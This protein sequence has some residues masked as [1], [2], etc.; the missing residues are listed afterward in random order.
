M[1]PIFVSGAFI[2][3]L[4]GAGCVHFEQRMEIFADGSAEVEL[5]Y[6]ISE[7]SMR[8]LESGQQLIDTWQGRAS[9]PANWFANEK[10]VRAYL[11]GDGIQVASYRQQRRNGKIHT[12]IVCRVASLS[13][14]LASGKVG[15]FRLERNRQGNFTLSADLVELPSS[16]AE[17]MGQYMAVC[18]DLRLKLEVVTPS[19]IV[20]STAH[21]TGKR[22]VSWEYVPDGDHSVF[23][24]TPEIAVTFEGSGLNWR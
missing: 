16:S 15:D 23:L 11:G 10:A 1:K 19:E 14:T 2:V 8:G 18:Q 12:T 21:Q 7:E 9:T 22:R 4:L 24:R 5:H 3:L 17:V 13:R 20:S 6:A